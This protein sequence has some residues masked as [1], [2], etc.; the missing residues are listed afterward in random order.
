MV[1]G[2]PAMR[3]VSQRESILKLVDSDG[4][5]G[6]SVCY[7]FACARMRQSTR[8]KYHRPQRVDVGLSLRLGFS[9]SVI[10]AWREAI[11]YAGLCK[12]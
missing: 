3:G 1:H 12:I 11:D 8:Q 2:G 5:L 10:A 7:S 4:F 6:F 9:K